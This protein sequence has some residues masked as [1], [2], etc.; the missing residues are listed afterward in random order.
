MKI[1]EKKS[2]F[3]ESSLKELPLTYRI[4]NI[5]DTKNVGE[6]YLSRKFSQSEKHFSGQYMVYISTKPISNFLIEDE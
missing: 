3:T 1:K 6:L 4:M 2:I 5:E